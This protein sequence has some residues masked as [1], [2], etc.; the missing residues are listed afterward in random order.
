LV[1]ARDAKA[2]GWEKV[3]AWMCPVCKP[4]LEVQPARRLSS[5]GLS[6]LLALASLGSWAPRGG[7]S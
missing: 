1:M 3:R 5:G 6:A 7:R 4:P 2:A